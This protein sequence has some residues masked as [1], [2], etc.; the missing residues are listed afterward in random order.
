M[1]EVSCA[2]R[3]YADAF[4]KPDQPFLD[5]F[6]FADDKSPRCESFTRG[7]FWSMA[8]RAARVLTGSSLGLGD[9]FAHYFTANRWQ[10]LAFRLAATM[11]GTVPVTINWQADSP[12]RIAYKIKLTVCRLVV[13]DRGTPTDTLDMLRER[14]PGLAV[15]DSERLTEQPELPES[16]FCTDESLGPDAT[17]IIIFT[18]GTTGQPKGVCLTYRSYRCNR[19]TFESFLQVG[20]GDL[21]APLVV[22][23]MHHTNSTSL[24]DWALRRPD[25]RLQLVERYSSQYWALL[26]GIVEKGYER[27]I[28]PS[29][30]RHF[31]YLE[32]LRVENRLPLEVDTLKQ[33]MNKVEFLIGSAPVGPTTIGRLQE[34]AGRIPW[35]RFGSTETCLQV[36]GTPLYLSEDERLRAFQ[37]GWRHT[38]SGDAQPG[39]YIGRAHPPFTETRIV[40][41]ITRSDEDYFV[42]C[43]EGEQG[44]LITRGDNLMREYVKN[45]DATYEA[46]H[47]GGWYTGLKDICFR[48]TSDIDGQD[49]FY[50]VSR[51]S[52]LMIRGAANYSYSQINAEVKS[53]IGERYSLPADA[54]DVAVVGL[55]ITSEHEDDCCVTVELVTDEARAKRNEIAETFL[56]EAAKRVS[57]GAKPDRLRFAAIPRNFKGAILVRELDGGFRAHIE[58]NSD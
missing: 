4:G 43:D 25:T 2:L 8:K 33:A 54:F 19:D 46:L 52:A 1:S 23:P 58:G 27:I 29:V 48:L 28:A 42:D 51:D 50:W 20:P 30:S 7:E 39:F 21:F 18:S 47:D 14:F 55:K 40:R 24:T 3:E 26:P 41:S 57:K 37:K 45:A 9:C 35:V 17:R 44:Y 32:N 5:Y 31:D 6:S 10:D 11:T 16:E 15:F 49:D 36:M 34:Y 38:R 22:N 53:F 13:V 56:I 12:E